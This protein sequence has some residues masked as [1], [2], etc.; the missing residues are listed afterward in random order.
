MRNPA[1]RH[2]HILSQLKAHGF[3]TVVELSKAMHV[4]EATIRRDLRNLEVRNLLFRTH[5]GAN[6][7]SHRVYDRPVSE[8]AKQHSGEKERIG[9]AAAAMVDANDSII[10]GSGTTVMQVAKH[11]PGHSN[12][13]VITSAV[14]VALELSHNTGIEIIQ[15]GGMVRL[16]STSTVGPTAETMMQAYSCRKLFLGVDGLELNHGLT[17]TNVLEANLNQYMIAAAHE[18]IVVTDSSKFGLRGFS[19][20][21]TLDRIDKVITDENALEATVRQFEERGI[22][23]VRV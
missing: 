5:G 6:P 22:E 12:L 9:R 16:T 7:P 14:N 8:K 4:S 19:Q 10:L 15:L 1:K 21:C 13:T 20:V 11:L 2:N 3:V 23:V 18:T 17:T